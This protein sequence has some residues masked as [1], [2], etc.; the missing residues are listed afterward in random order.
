MIIQACGT[1]GTALGKFTRR[2]DVAI[3]LW[4]A[5]H[6]IITLW[7]VRTGMEL[8]HID[9]G[10]MSVTNGYD[11][12]YEGKADDFSG[13]L[14]LALGT[15]PYGHTWYQVKGQRRQYNPGA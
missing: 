3:G 8:A 14:S 2:T 7:S 9:T 13:A 11:G 5:E 1:G 12:A 4:D 6:R 10:L 15:P